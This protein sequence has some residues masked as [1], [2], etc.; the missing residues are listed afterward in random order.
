VYRLNQ[1]QVKLEDMYEHE[2]GEAARYISPI[3]QDQMYKFLSYLPNLECSVAYQPI[4]R[5]I[6]K[7]QLSIS[8]VFSWNDRWNGNS[9]PFWIIVDNET[10]ILH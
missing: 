6:L 2:L 9:E 10:E 1:Y 3:H 8:A 7:V 5:T 4:T